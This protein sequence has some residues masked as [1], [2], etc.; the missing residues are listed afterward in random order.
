MMQLISLFK[1]QGWKVTFASSAAESDHMADLESAG[2]ETVSIEMN[3][4]SFDTFIRELQ[5]SVVLFDRFVTEEQFGWRV[6][7]HCPQA[8]RILDTED[9]HCLRRTRKE[10]LKAGKEFTETDLLSSEDARREIASIYRCDLTIMISEFEMELL[11]NVFKVDSQLLWYLPFLL[12]SI[13]ESV[14]KQWPDYESRRHFVTIGNFRHEPNADAVEYLY[15]EIWPLIH[16][17]LPG[18]EL[19]IYG[20]Y[21]TKRVE[22]LHKPDIGFYIEGRASDAQKVVQNARICLA[23]LRFGAGLKGKLVEA[24]QCGTPSVTTKVGAEGLNGSSPWGGVIVDDPEKIADS[25]VELYKTKSEWCEAQRKGTEIIDKRFVQPEWGKEFINRIQAILGT[26]DEHRKHNFTGQMLM[27][28]RMASTK[29]MSRWI[30]AK[31][32]KRHDI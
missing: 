8:I 10:A 32:K 5:P 23:P 6:A 17:Q 15:S 20:A 22:Q 3:S 26:I 16:Q 28:H 21:P 14:T 18:A 1:E 24:M 7:E 30:E 27:H 31:N 4:S 19:H 12:D 29:Y 11:Q 9:L 13:D 2:V 25:A